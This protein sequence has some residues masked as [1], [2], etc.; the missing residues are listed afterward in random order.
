MTKKNTTNAKSHSA[1]NGVAGQHAAICK[2]LDDIDRKRKTG[3]AREHT[4]RGILETLLETLIP[5]STAVNDGEQIDCG[6]PDFNIIDR[7]SGLT[8]GY[9]EAKNIGVGD[10][11]G[12][13]ATGNKEQFD[14][15]KAA[16]DNIAFTDYIDFIFY[17]NGER[18][19]SVSIAEI[20]GDGIRPLP[21]NFGKFVSLITELGKA[22]PQN[23]TSPTQLAQLMA[24]KARLLQVAAQK[25]LSTAKAN[26]TRLWK[27]LEDFK[28][29]L[30][31]ETTTEQFADIYAQTLTYGL[32][33]ARL[34]DDGNSPFTLRN[35]AAFV[36][37]SNPFLQELFD[38]L[39]HHIA[40]DLKWFVDDIVNLFAAAN[41][42]T[43]MKDYGKS[44]RQRDPMIHFYEDFLNAYDAGLRKDR[45]VWYTPLPIV[46]FIVR[47]VDDLLVWRFGIAEGLASRDRAEITVKETDAKGT[48]TS[49]SKIVPKVQILDPATG[50]GT[51]LAECVNRIH[52]RFRKNAGMWPGYVAEDLIPRLN[53]FEILMASYTMAH[54]KLDLV[55]SATGYHH[56]NDKRFN[57]FLTN[58]L[59]IQDTHNPNSPRPLF[60]M[61]LAEEA[62]AANAVKRDCPVMVVVGNPPYSGE[63]QN[64]G[65]AF[66][67]FMQLLKVYKHEPGGKEKLKER[68]PKWLNDDYVKFLRLAQHYVEKNPNGG[69]GIV[70][71][72]NPH[73]F[74]DNPTFR[75]MRWHLLKT[76]DEIYVL[77]LHGN[78]KKHETSPDGSKDENVFTIQQG[79]SINIFVRTG[80]KPAD[81]LGKVFYADLWG[82]RKDKYHFLESTDFR[83]VP[84]KEVTPTAPMY[85][86]VPKDTKGEAKY[87]SGFS[88]IDL[89]PVN[90]VGICSKRDNIAIQDSKDGIRDVISDFASMSESQLK[91]KYHVQSESRDQKVSYAI[92]TV[93]QF[94]AS[95]ELFKTIS[96]R[97]FDKRWT[98]YTPRSRGFLAYPV[99]HV[100]SHLAKGENIGI[101]IGRQGQAVGSGA[102]NVVF[103]TDSIVDLNMFYR[104]GGCTFPLYL[105]QDMMGNVEKVPNFDKATFEKIATGMKYKPKPE[106]LFDYI[107]AVLHTPEYRERYKEFLKVDFPRIPYPANAAVFKKLAKIGGELRETHLLKASPSTSGRKSVAN[108][109]IDGNRLVEDVRFVN[110]KV[111]INDEQYFDHVPEEA[112]GMFI[113]GYQ[114]AQKWLKDRKGRI[115]TLDDI[116]H[117]QA[118]IPALMRTSAL[119]QKLSALSKDWLK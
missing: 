32:F 91:D 117:Y 26:G 4:Y 88:L 52:E 96:Y 106:E 108:F 68:N 99:Y 1:K 14:R 13:K 34:H 73:G 15:Y 107:Y 116:E 28:R 76:F 87:Q 46:Q 105:Y 83:D 35:A 24:A 74:L 23:I 110:G 6:A 29:V 104:G 55:L 61:A 103:V 93:K 90:G 71:Y 43:I 56:Q 37:Q 65:K 79:V 22:S 89:C 98:Y 48:E 53:G 80:K 111:Y 94:G 101:I 109:P 41:V 85:F 16:L 72:I 36:P 63:S 62:D 39:S 10:L 21:D 66:E 30:L 47:A 49:H 12:K 3:K 60:S 112:W 54:I 70:G 11:E 44:T 97:P 75:G 114:P 20:A 64:K 9:V 45:G 25:F 100:M 8:I 2:Y 95:E 7:E 102:W 69:H 119:M 38:Q 42:A 57:V 115:L 58:S 19:D 77:N 84:Y 82:K 78:A 5:S 18:I 118:I 59:E 67:E 40:D 81:A 17:K 113:G 50:T 27:L 86:F 31:P 92:A 51:F 33:V